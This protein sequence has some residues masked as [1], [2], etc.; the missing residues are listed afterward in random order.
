MREM[1]A[2]LLEL[3][4]IALEEAGLAD[5]LEELCQAYRS[6]LGIPVS[7]L[8][9]QPLNLSPPI[10]HAVFRVAQE[11]LGNAARHAEPHAIDVRVTVAEG[12]VA[13]TISDDGQGFDP[14]TM[15]GLR[16]MGLQLMRERIGELGGTV[17]VTSAPGRGTTVSAELPVD[18]D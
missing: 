1:R 2:M 5:A 9:D 6:R 10:E 17:E 11:S 16:G 12:R 8:I 13:M 7:A 18:V 4:P 15:T 14:A 3:R